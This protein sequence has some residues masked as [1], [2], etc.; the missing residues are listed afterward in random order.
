MHEG[1]T[2]LLTYGVSVGW[3]SVTVHDLSLGH[4]AALVPVLLRHNPLIGWLF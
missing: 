4:F 1:V 3:W 2:V